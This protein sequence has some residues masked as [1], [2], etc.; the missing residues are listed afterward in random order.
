MP[1]VALPVQMDAETR[2]T[3]NQLIRSSSTPQSLAMR[4]RIVLAAA[5]GSSNQQIAAELKIPAITV[6]KWRRSFAMDGIEGLRDAARSGRP[7]K[8]D[9]G[10]R[11]RVQTRVCQQPETQ[12]RWS[13][14]RLASELGLPSSTVHAMLV[15]AKLQPHRI[16]T[17]AFSPDPE[18]EAKLLDIVGLYLNPPENAL[19][20]CVDEKPSIQA[21]D[22]TQP[23]LPLRAKKPRSWTNEYV[24]HGTQTLLAALEIATGK[25]VAHVRDRR[26]TEDFLSFMH[27]VVKSYPSGELH[28]VLDNLNIHKNEAARQWLLQHPRVHFHYTPTHASWMN[29]IECFFSIL[30]RQALTQSVQRS[31]KDLKEF[32]LRY[33]DQYSRNPTPFTWTKGPDQLQRIIEATKEYQAAHPK[34][35]KRRAARNTKKD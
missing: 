25:I 18:F 29:M 20:L 33:L 15:A 12:S 7:P 10:V 9:A 35:P 1:R 5:D 27:D 24:R 4:S 2:S 34:Q 13:V 17:F 16:R 26:T 28:V 23:L 32:L 22:R 8:H 31:K 6:G 14:R 21:L 3:L 30:T 11:Q 19:V